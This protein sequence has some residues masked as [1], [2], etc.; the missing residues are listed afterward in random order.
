MSAANWTDDDSSVSDVHTARTRVITMC[1]RCRYQLRGTQLLILMA[2]A[3]HVPFASRWS[4][5]S[6]DRRVASNRVNRNIGLWTSRKWTTLRLPCRRRCSK[7]KYRGYPHFA[8]LTAHHPHQVV[9]DFHCYCVLIDYVASAVCLWSRIRPTCVF[10][11]FV[12]MW[13]SPKTYPNKEY[14]NFVATVNDIYSR[15]SSGYHVRLNLRNCW[16]YACV[17]WKLWIKWN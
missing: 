2:I 12:Y 17:N 8:K 4:S 10:L 7:C 13:I 16:G 14:C 3:R 15:R 11:A 9:Y 6:H 5:D 1:Y